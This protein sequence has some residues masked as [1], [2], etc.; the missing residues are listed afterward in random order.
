MVRQAASN[1]RIGKPLSS[2]NPNALFVKERAFAAFGDEHFLVRGIVN[3]PGHD[4]VFALECHRN[5]KMRNAMQEIGGAVER[6]DNPGMGFVGAFAVAAF[7]AEKSIA[8]SRLYEFGV[9]LLL[10]TTIGR[11]H[12][13]GGPLERDL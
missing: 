2:G 10:G 4:S 6:V 9:K 1:D 5:G 13:I 3:K 11:R 12:E 8:G 7:F